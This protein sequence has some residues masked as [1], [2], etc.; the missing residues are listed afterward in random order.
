MNIMSQSNMQTALLLI[1]LCAGYLVVSIASKEK[2]NIRSTGY[3][4]GIGVI[5]LSILLI[6]SSLLINLRILGEANMMDP[7]SRMPMRHMMM[8]KRQLKGKFSPEGRSDS[9]MMVPTKQQPTTQKTKES[10]PSKDMSG[11]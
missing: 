5:A 3:A 7:R 8:E 2:Q 11:K 9:M 4:I 10:C 1:A 6:I